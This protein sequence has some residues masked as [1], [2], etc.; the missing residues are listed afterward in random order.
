M[1]EILNST[2]NKRYIGSSLDIGRRWRVHLRS[3]QRGQHHSLHLQRAWDKYGAAVFCFQIVQECRPDD[4]VVAE[5]TLI[6]SYGLDQLYNVSPYAEYSGR[7][8]RVG[9]HNT[10]EHNA[11]IGKANSGRP[12]WNKGGSNTWGGKIA[13]SRVAKFD[14]QV[15][16]ENED[17]KMQH[18]A[19]TTAAAR[20]LGLSRKSVDNILNG[21][22]R[23][24]RDGWTFRKVP[25]EQ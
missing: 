11:A 6:D 23:R 8:S 4:I 25:K 17:G 2:T 19:S 12:S 13:A 7:Y 22:A 16:A 10:P 1:Y 20:G 24:T 18:F 15:A 5:Q 14:Y 9:M 3:L 21:R